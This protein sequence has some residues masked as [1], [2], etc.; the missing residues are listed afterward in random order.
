MSDAHPTDGDLLSAFRP[1]AERI[2]EVQRQASRL[3][4]FIEDRE[5]LQCPTC[6]LTEDIAIEGRLMTYPASDLD[7]ALESD[8]PL[9]DSGLRF[10]KIS[11]RDFLCPECGAVVEQHAETL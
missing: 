1:L 11:G 2:Q 9:T 3:G 10:L 4:I 6:G 8:K 5:L 7:A